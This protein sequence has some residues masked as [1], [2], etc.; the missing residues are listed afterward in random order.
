MQYI[1][2]S[3]FARSA[4]QSFPFAAALSSPLP[5]AVFSP[6][7]SITFQLRVP[8]GN[9]WQLPQAQRQTAESVGNLTQHKLRCEAEVSESVGCICADRGTVKNKE[10]VWG[11]GRATLASLQLIGRMGGR[12]V[13]GNVFNTNMAG[14]RL[15][16]NLLNNRNNWHQWCPVIS[17]CFPHCLLILTQL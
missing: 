2:P 16:Y 1:T 8:P 4:P 10:G 12:G 15:S 17:Y 13:G 11:G 7:N 5:S 3:P 9:P 6:S 14:V